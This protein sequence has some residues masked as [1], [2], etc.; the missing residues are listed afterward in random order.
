VT[1]LSLL[2]VVVIDPALIAAV[3]GFQ[4]SLAGGAS[5]PDF[6]HLSALRTESKG[7]RTNKPPGDA[8]TDCLLQVS[9]SEPN[10]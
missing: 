4:V 1:L 5:A 9:R 2:L 10:L 7:W 8:E 3:L 6:E